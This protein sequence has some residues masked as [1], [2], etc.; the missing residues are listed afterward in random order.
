MSE[1]VIDLAITGMTCAS[2]VGRLEKVLGRQDGV[3]KAEVNLATA[4]ARVVVEDGRTAAARLVSA[5]EKAGFGAAAV[6]AGAPMAEETGARGEL[7]RVIGAA[8][9]S[10][11]L[12]LP[13]LLPGRDAMVS[14]PLQLVLASLVLFGFGSRFFLGAWAAVRSGHG[15]MDLLVALGTSAAWG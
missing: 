10:L 5:V 14:P 6:Q 1:T 3:V 15:T 9:L 11:P 2:C 13:M 12:A 7:L 8:L 4:R